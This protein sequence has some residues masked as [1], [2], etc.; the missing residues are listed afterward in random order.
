LVGIFC[1]TANEIFRETLGLILGQFLCLLFDPLLL[2][3]IF[4]SSRECRW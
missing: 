3:F 4:A 2:V 1:V